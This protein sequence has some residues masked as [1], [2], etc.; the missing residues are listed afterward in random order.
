MTEKRIQF[1][2]FTDL[3]KVVQNVIEKTNKVI[4]INNQLKRQLDDE[5]NKQP[6]VPVT[7]VQ[8]IL[9]CPQNLCAREINYVK[10]R[11]PF[12]KSFTCPWLGFEIEN[13]PTFNGNIKVDILLKI[14]KTLVYSEVFS[15][16]NGQ[17]ISS[18]IAAPSYINISFNGLDITFINS[19]YQIY[20][21]DITATSLVPSLVK[22]IKI[23]SPEN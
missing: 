4:S 12:Y 19:N 14:D 18:N 11:T 16:D 7:P 23:T 6:P 1:K 8:P 22:A 10:I 9:N 21:I 3:S 2:G 17:V 20:T 13:E 5:K 15:I